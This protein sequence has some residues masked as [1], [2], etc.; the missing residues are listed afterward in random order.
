M[1]CC[2]HHSQMNCHH[3]CQGCQGGHHQVYPPVNHLVR[4]QDHLYNYQ[5]YYTEVN[6]NLKLGIRWISEIL[7]TTIY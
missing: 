1:I 7:N 6:N 3:H 4:N 2:K 5:G